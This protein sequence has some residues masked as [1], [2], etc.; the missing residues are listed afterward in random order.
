MPRSVST[1]LRG[2]GEVERMVRGRRE[3]GS[4]ELG[5]VPRESAVM[6]S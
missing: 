5:E 4:V 6:T 1:E 2:E 3:G